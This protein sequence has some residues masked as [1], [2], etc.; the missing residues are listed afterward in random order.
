MVNSV[1]CKMH[2]PEYFNTAAYLQPPPRPTL[3]ELLD[4]IRSLRAQLEIARIESSTDPLTGLPNRRALIDFIKS[5]L[6]EL[7][8]GAEIFRYEKEVDIENRKSQTVGIAIGFIDLDGFKNI[9]D[10]YGHKAGDDVLKAVAKLLQKILRETDIAV[11]DNIPKGFEETAGRLGGDEFVIAF[12][13]TDTL[14]LEERRKAIEKKLNTLIVET[15]DKNGTP[16]KVKVGGTLG[17]IDCDITK[18]AESNL[19][20]ADSAMYKLKKSKKEAAQ[21]RISDSVASWFVVTP[22]PR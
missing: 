14:Q 21:Q 11:L 2:P 1:R 16:I 4:E 18:S 9:N 17:L 13:Q 19:E 12:L 22:A 7:R 6:E 20:I 8:Q 3:E 15:T 10:T 5:A